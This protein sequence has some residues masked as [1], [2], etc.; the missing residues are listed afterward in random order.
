MLTH[1]LANACD[2]NTPRVEVER[3]LFRL[4]LIHFDDAINAYILLRDDEPTE[5]FVP[6]L[7]CRF[8]VAPAHSSQTMYAGS[9]KRQR[10]CY[11]ESFHQWSLVEKRA[12]FAF[13]RSTTSK[14]DGPT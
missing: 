3:Y 14:T 10:D 9:L 4:Q 12:R 1:K 8:P 2:P 11:V 5:Q 7:G 13:K 6:R